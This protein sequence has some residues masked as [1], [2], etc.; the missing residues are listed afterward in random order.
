MYA[1][2][3]FETLMKLMKHSKGLNTIVEKLLEQLRQ[4]LKPLPS[5]PIAFPSSLDW[6]L[7][8]LDYLMGGKGILLMDISIGLPI[9]PCR[10][11]RRIPFYRFSCCMLL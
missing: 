7:L 8:A 10:I 9:P 4:H 1:H 3:V 5:K 2:R 6:L 11:F